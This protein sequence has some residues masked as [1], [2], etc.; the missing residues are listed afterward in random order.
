VGEVRASTL[1][2]E[3]EWEPH[4]GIRIVEQRYSNPSNDVFVAFV[5]LCAN[6]VRVDATAEPTATRSAASRG[7]SVG[8]QL[9]VNGDFYAS[10]PWRVRS[11]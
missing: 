11:G 5:D 3:T 6:G 1:E 9:A 10:D 4:S 2:S 7:A 8:A